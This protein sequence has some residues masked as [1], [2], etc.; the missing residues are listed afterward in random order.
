MN[1]WLTVLLTTVVLVVMLRGLYTLVVRSIGSYIER[2]HRAMEH[3]LST[4]KPPPQWLKRGRDRPEAA[5]AA[6][7]KRLDRLRNY[8]ARSTLVEDD[9]TRAELSDAMAAVRQQWQEDD[10]TID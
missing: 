9:R 1:I 4:R 10:W 7:I 6:C 3:I 8:A 5:R 2:R